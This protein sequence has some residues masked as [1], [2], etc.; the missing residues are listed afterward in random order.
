MIS[1]C[2][3]SVKVPLD[4]SHARALLDDISLE[5]GR[6][7]WIALAGPNGAGKTTLLH[8]IAGL[9]EPA[10]GRIERTPPV[11]AALLL[12]EP[13]NQFVTTSV[14]HEL[15]LSVPGGIP[16][17]S[18]SGRIDQVVE[19]FGLSA[20]LERNPHRLSGGE[21]QRLALATVWLG[22]PDLLLLDEPTAYLDGETA[23]QCRS[24]VAQAHRR[25][26]TVVWATP[27]GEEL[28]AA[29]R[30]VCLR[31][32]RVVY[33]GG[34]EALYGWA[35]SAGFALV[36]PPLRRLAGEL[37][38]AVTAPDVSQRID[39]AAE[40]GTAGL[41]RAIAPLVKETSAD[42]R[43]TAGAGGRVAGACAVEFTGVQFGYGGR[44]ALFGIDLGVR[45]GECV[46]LTG[47]NGA[48][49]S[50]ALALAAGVFDPATGSVER[51]FAG[52]RGSG[53]GGAFLLFQS[54]ERLFFAETVAEELSFGLER[55]G[56]AAAERARRSRSALD[57]V[58][59]PPESFLERA[60]LTLSP[61]EM[62][63]VA[64]A[65]ALS[66]EPGLLLL[67]EPTSCLDAEAV[68]V[69]SS[70]LE[71]RRSEGGTTMVASHDAAF[72]AGVCDRIYWLRDGR[73]E[74]ELSTAGGRL[75][76]GSEWPGEPLAVLDLQAH[77]AVLGADISPRAL[78]ARRLAERLV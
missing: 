16:V 51:S 50:T 63:R 57:R 22:Q 59:L 20:L 37:A 74:A 8:T 65:I 3:V 28:E 10:A 9:V 60:P 42:D 7:A 17:G 41:A 70:I 40:G 55:R 6:G 2:G 38:G 75:P 56:V 49:K 44:P 68:S 24:F 23:S 61:G 46:G 25:G 76:R 78:T 1:L 54:P 32:G 77:L 43:D 67:D 64:F 62:R 12:Q 26:V 5:I 15:E 71:A 31:Q 73:I 18:R 52:A 45:Q 36:R 48:G 4:V 34:K 66:L 13:D 35:Q 53:R 30:V 47:P 19:R 29:D 21:K 27:G 11:R 14:R 39:A 72:L 58:G 69:L 33:D